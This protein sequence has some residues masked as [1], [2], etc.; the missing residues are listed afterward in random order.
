MPGPYPLATLAPI[1]GPTGISILSFEDILLSLIATFQ[2][3]YGADIYIPPD[4]QDYQWL[5]ALATA[6]NDQ[7]QATVAAYN[8]FSPVYAQ[9]SGL[10]ALVKINGLAREPGSSSTAIL[11]IAGV[12]G[13]EIQNG[14]A[15]DANGNLWDLPPLVIIPETG[16]IQV[17]ATCATLGAVAAP[18]NTI[19]TIYTVVLGWQSVTNASAATIGAPV[20]SDAILR[21][22]Q[23][24]STALPAQTPLQSILA[25][26][27]NISGVERYAIYENSTSAT[28]ANGLPPHSIAVVVE[29]GDID[30]V[31]QVI[32]E[33]KSP[34]TGTYGTTSV[35]VD[36]PVDLPITINFFELSLTPIYVIVT[37]QPLANYVSSTAAVI[38]AAI[39]AFINALSIGGDVFF[40]SMFGPATLYG[41]PLASTFKVTSIAIGTAPSPSGISDIDIAFNAAA[42]CSVANVT[43]NT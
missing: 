24:A 31:A 36:D 27:A 15:Q 9:G 14:V 39:V 35:I 32:E 40:N 29:G 25:A 6:I 2:S 41:N 5:V 38:Q 10:S 3:I 34:G 4:S 12:V 8:S 20:E 18:A 33:K 11:T 19:T 7:N 28:D 30:D 43:V 16:A 23:A 1:I 17:T 37:I 22:R 26:V 21:Q 42:S 13:T